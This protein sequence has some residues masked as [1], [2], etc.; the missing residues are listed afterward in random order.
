MD[1]TCQRYEQNAVGPAPTARKVRTSAY[2]GGHGLE[3]LEKVVRRPAGQRLESPARDRVLLLRSMGGISG[4]GGP[5]ELPW[6]VSASPIAFQIA[7]DE[8]RVPTDSCP[9]VKHVGVME[10]VAKELLLLLSATPAGEFE[11][12]L[13]I[14]GAPCQMRSMRRIWRML[15]RRESRTRR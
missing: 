9:G 2:K 5:F 12:I 14:W 8:V 15:L 11:F 13:H 4:G 1:T 10:D 3:A 6:S 7:H